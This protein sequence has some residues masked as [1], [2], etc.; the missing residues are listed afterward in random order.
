MSQRV[1][2]SAKRTDWNRGRWGLF[3]TQE[4]RMYWVEERSVATLFTLEAALAYVRNPI[5]W[6]GTRLSNSIITIDAV[7]F[8]GEP[9]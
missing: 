4:R 1:L 2:Y 5:S 6:D 3:V 9:V 8:E 7:I